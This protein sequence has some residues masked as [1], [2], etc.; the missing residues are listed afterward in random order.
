M[1]ARAM[2]SVLPSPVAISTRRTVR[3]AERTHDLDA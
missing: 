3:D 2:V 1:A